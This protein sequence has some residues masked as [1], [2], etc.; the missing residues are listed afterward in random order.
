MEAGTAATPGER[1]GRGKAKNPLS[2]FVK[3]S[4]M[5]LNMIAALALTLMMFLTVLDVLLRAGGRP[6]V[7]AYEIVS[8]MMAIV[9]GFGIPQVS[10][11]GAHVFMEI[12]VEKLSP[13]SKQI[14]ET[15]TRLLCFGLFLFVGY[16][17]IMVGEEFHMSGEV[18]PTLRIPFYPVAYGVAVCC[19]LECL[20]FVLQI[21]EIWRAR[22][23]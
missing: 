7:G 20:V 13:R 12:G 23:E 10:L 16:N 18:S 2:G 21:V 11:D 19:F 6:I 22:H 14:M 8:L 9:I 3:R 5:F 1:R 17:L 4:S 15:F